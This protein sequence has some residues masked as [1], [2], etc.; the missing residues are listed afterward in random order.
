MGAY[1]RLNPLDKMTDHQQAAEA[2]KFWMAPDDAMF[3]PATIAI[4]LKRSLSWLQN[5][6]C[7]G[8]GIPFTKPDGNKIVYYQ[9]ADVLEYIK[10][11]KME[12]T[13]VKTT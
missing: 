7:T 4:I 9:K 6:R 13:E 5:K 8:D 3:P 1:K 10:K 12:H 11:N 2:V